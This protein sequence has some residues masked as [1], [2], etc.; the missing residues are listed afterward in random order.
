MAHGLQIAT[1][2][3]LRW[4][5]RGNLRSESRWTPQTEEEKLMNVRRRDPSSWNGQN[6]EVTAKME[7]VKKVGLSI[8]KRM[9]DLQP[10]GLRQKIPR[11]KAT[12]LDPDGH[13]RAS[14]N[15]NGQLP[16]I[17]DRF[18]FLNA[19][20]SR[21]L[22]FL[23]LF[24]FP[25]CEDGARSFFFRHLTAMRLSWSTLSLRAVSPLLRASISYK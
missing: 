16:L 11:P 7:G 24:P 18:F 12:T 22:L 21:H 20:A 2:E 6:D 9:N 19:P 10:Y 4:M 15:R 5:R 25:W 14:R 23:F 17:M 3:S 8:R 13:R 1:R